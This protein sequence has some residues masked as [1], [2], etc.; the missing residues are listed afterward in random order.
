MTLSDMCN[1]QAADHDL[2]YF[3][4]I[5]LRILCAS[6]LYSVDDCVSYM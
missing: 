5:K 2:I 4:D 1:R 6:V 3:I